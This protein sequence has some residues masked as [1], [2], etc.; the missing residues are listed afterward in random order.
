MSLPSWKEARNGNI[1]G[2]GKKPEMRVQNQI[3]N[4]K[5]LQNIDQLN[6]CK[7]SAGVDEEEVKFG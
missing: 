2:A 7:V 6:Y 5:T 3:L 1:Y 4:H